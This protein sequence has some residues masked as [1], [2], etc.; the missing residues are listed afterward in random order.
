MLKP[1]AIP[2]PIAP[3]IFL[4]LSRIPVMRQSNNITCK[5]NPDVPLTGVKSSLAPGES[6]TVTG[7]T[8]ASADT[9]TC[10]GQGAISGTPVSESG[11]ATCTSSIAKPAIDVKKYVSTDGRNWSDANFPPGI[12]VTLCSDNTYSWFHTRKSV[13]NSTVNT[14]CYSG[15][16]SSGNCGKVYF[17]F[18]A[19]N[20]GN[21]TLTNISLTDSEYPLRTCTVPNTLNPGR[22]FTW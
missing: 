2:V 4:P 21:T 12:M 6:F 7:T 1:R 10:S 3:T 20:T 14:K 22:S 15:C 16:G 8:K 19:K 9:L 17:K 11:S 18:V 13:Q 5:D